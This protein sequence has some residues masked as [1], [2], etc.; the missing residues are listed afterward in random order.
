MAMLILLSVYGAVRRW[1]APE[2][3]GKDDQPV[4]SVERSIVAESQSRIDFL[5]TS[6]NKSF[7]VATLAR[8]Y[9]VFDDI[10]TKEF[11]FGVSS[12]SLEE[13][14][15]RFG[16]RAGGDIRKT[17]LAAIF[18]MT[19]VGLPT[20]YYGDEYGMRGGPDPDDRR[21]FDWSQGSTSNASVALFQKLIAIRKTYSALRSGS[22]I[23]LFTDDANK[24]YSFGRMDQNNRLAVILNDD[25][26]THTVTIP[27]YQLSMINGS[28]VTDQ[29]TGNTYQVQNGQLTVTVH[30]Y[31]GAILTS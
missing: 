5:T 22:F 17:E 1:F 2:L 7:Y 13:L 12:V 3:K 4:P 9:E 18:Q 31:N 16:E 24:I 15:T 28:S 30:A 20:I 19:Y 11:G 8:L 25:A 29:L 6:R 10:M 27:A 26:S 14:Q 23:T 21:T